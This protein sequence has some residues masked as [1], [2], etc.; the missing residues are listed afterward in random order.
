MTSVLTTKTDFTNTW[1][2]CFFFPS[3]CSNRHCVC[4]RSCGLYPCTQAGERDT[5]NGPL[6]GLPGD[7]DL[8]PARGGSGSRLPPPGCEGVAPQ[9]RLPWAVRAGTGSPCR[10][11]RLNA[12]P[13]ADGTHVPLSPRMPTPVEAHSESTLRQETT[14]GSRRGPFL[15]K[16]LEVP[17]F[18]KRG[19]CGSS[20]H[21][22]Q[23]KC[24]RG[25]MKPSLRWRPATFLRLGRGV[26]RSL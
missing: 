2:V 1:K 4:S 15:R 20:P 11:R 9:A 5:G 14:H 17:G 12:P 7:L 13:R 19:Q 24:H 23:L 3:I 26:A 8:H 10:A 21:S 6:R 16:P 22:R 18:W 25:C